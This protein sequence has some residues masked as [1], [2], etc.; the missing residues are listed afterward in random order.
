MSMRGWMTG[1]VGLAAIALALWAGAA[2]AAEPATPDELKAGKFIYDR[3]CHHCHGDKGRGDGIAAADLDPRPRD[4]TKGLFKFRTTPSGTIPTLDDLAR[5]V[6]HGLTGT[7]MGQWSEFS[8]KDRRAVLLYVMTFSERFQT[9]TP[10][11]IT[12]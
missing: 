7:A 5:T 12:V 1:I 11:P 8:A 2:Q 10:S 4:F 6:T 3:G 9:E